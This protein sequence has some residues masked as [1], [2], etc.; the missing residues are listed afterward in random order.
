[1]YT[2]TQQDTYGRIENH[3]ESKTTFFSVT[4][5]LR[6]YTTDSIQINIYAHKVNN[7]ETEWPV[8]DLHLVLLYSIRKQARREVLKIIRNKFTRNAV[9][10]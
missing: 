8:S 7:F 6:K 9:N 4:C 2:P 10:Y 3:L 5:V 1:M